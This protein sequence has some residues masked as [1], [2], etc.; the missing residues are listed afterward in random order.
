MRSRPTPALVLSIALGAAACSLLAPDDDY[1]L[2]DSGT[3]GGGAGGGGGGGATTCE[4]APSCE[5]PA[6][7]PTVT[8]SEAEAVMLPAAVANAAPGD[9]IALEP[10]TYNLS[11]VLSFKKSGVTLRST[12]GVADDVVIDAGQL[13][14]IVAIA[15]SDVT[16]SGITIQNASE[17]AISIG[18][19]LGTVVERPRLCGVHVVD[20]GE[21]FLQAPAENGYTDCGRVEGSRLELTDAGRGASCSTDLVSG[22][23]V[24]GGRGWVLTDSELVGFYCGAPPVLST[25]DCSSSGIGVVFSGGAR[26]TTI[27]RSR[28]LDVA[29]GIALGYTIT[30][31]PPR[32]YADAPYP[33]VTVDHY[34]G[35]LRNNVVVGN[36]HCFD[37]GIELNHA[38]R[39]D[40]VHNTVIHLGT[41]L[42][43]AIDRRYPGTD[44]VLQNN[45]HLGPLTLRDGAIPG[46]EA[47]NVEVPDVTSYFVDAAGFDVHLTS[48]ATNAID[49]GV[50]AESAGLDIDGEPHDNGAAPDVGADER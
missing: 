15:A 1:F 44:V 8:L 38:R 13:P 24:T 4:P 40:V 27:E 18:G 28:F 7:A 31:T 22:I 6:R 42:F 41:V 47:A 39:P 14:V 12:T 30:S 46:V 50:P 17:T 25:A 33:D 49:R 37:T 21:A 43:S 19:G 11:A 26:D 5:A 48:S 3:G 23:S 9:T 32:A 45:L 2:G 29:R 20:G 16:L 35:V 10:G 36:P 34:D